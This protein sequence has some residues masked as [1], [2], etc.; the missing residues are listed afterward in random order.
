[1]FQVRATA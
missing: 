1:M